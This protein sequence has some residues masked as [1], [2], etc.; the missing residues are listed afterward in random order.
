MEEIV[1]AK[2]RNALLRLSLADNHLE[3]EIGRYYADQNKNVFMQISS[4]ET[5]IN[6]F[7]KRIDT[8]E[9]DIRTGKGKP[10]YA[11]M[12][13]EMQQ[14][15]EDK[16][17]EYSALSGSMQTY[18]LP[19]HYIDSVKYDVQTP[20][21]LFDSETSNPETIHQLVAKYVSRVFIQRETEV[22]H[23]IM[24]FKTNNAVLYEKTVVAEYT[25]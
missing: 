2:L 25:P 1:S 19:E 20:I 23:I 10:Y 24:Q 8:I 9:Q 6:F 3:E 21:A 22:I 4:L 13:S 17:N 5:E 18:T 7:Q 16:Q 11:D 12:I 15:L 14:E